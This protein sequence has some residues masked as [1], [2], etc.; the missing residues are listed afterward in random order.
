[1]IKT[2]FWLQKRFCKARVKIT[3]VDF[4]YQFCNLEAGHYSYAQIQNR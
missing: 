2:V 4:R 1:M 3:V